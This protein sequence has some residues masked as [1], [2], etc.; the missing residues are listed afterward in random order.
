VHRWLTFLRYELL[1]HIK[2][3]RL[4]L[5]LG[6][7]LA[8][9]VPWKLLLL[10]E[11]ASETL[12]R[13]ADQAL[14][15]RPN[16]VL[17]FAG[18]LILITVD[19]VARVRIVGVHPLLFTKPFSPLSFLLAC[20]AALVTLASLLAGI[21]LTVRYLID[22][23]FFGLSLPMAPFGWIL[24]LGAIPL[25]IGVVAVAIWL[26]TVV[27]HNIS[28]CLITAILA[29]AIFAEVN[30]FDLPLLGCQVDLTV[31]LTGQ[32]VPSIGRDLDWARYVSALFNTTVVALLLVSLACYHTRRQEPQRKVL[33]K[34]GERWTD[35]P[36]FLGFLPNLKIDRHA[37]LAVHSAFLTT[38]IL[39]AVVGYRTVEQSMTTSSRVQRWAVELRRDLRTSDVAT[40]G[41][42][43]RNYSGEIQI[44]SRSRANCDLRMEVA[45]T[46]N[47]AVDRVAFSIPFG[48]EVRRF[49]EERSRPLRWRQWGNILVADLS[50]P[51]APG[52]TTT[53]RLAYEGS[54][55]VLRIGE[56]IPFSTN[57]SI[58][59]GHLEEVGLTLGSRY[60]YIN[61]WLLPKSLALRR[62]ANTLVSV[63]MPQLFTTDLRVALFN[64]L[65]MTSPNGL[66]EP[67]GQES[68]TSRVRLRIA[69][70][71][72]DFSLFA[73]PYQ[74][75]EQQFGSLVLHIHCFPAD[76]EIIE[77][78]LAELAE[79]V[80]RWGLL[81]GSAKGQ[82]C[83]LVE[84]PVAYWTDDRLPSGHLAATD[85]DRLRRYRPLLRTH[86]HEG[87]RA[88]DVYQ[89]RLSTVLAGKLLGESFHPD[90]Q[91]RPL[92]EALY[93][94]LIG[95]V[96]PSE[97]GP[98]AHKSVRLFQPRRVGTLT[99]F[100]DPVRAARFN[101]PLVQR[102]TSPTFEGFDA[103]HIW[104]ML[105]YLLEDDKFAAFLRALVNEYGDRIVTLADLRSLAERFYGGSLEWFFQQWFFGT[106]VP[107]LE[108][109]EARASMIENER[110]RDIEYDV[111]VVIA[112]KGQGRMPVPVVLQTERD[113]VTRLVWLDSDTTQTVMLHVPDRPETVFLDPE[114][115]ITQE[116]VADRET[117][118]RGPAWRKVRIIE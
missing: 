3:W 8:P 53:V 92:R 55:V 19:T 75:I 65:Q 118:T 106:G 111:R 33:G 84:A 105:H 20:W 80:E 7:L 11:I 104:R 30:A 66:I 42:M 9:T 31:P 93:W 36:T 59:V 29:G 52:C 6:V 86:Q 26:R 77:F 60:I 108:I 13:I 54:P 64:N 5:C 68:G 12:D 94:Y 103:T 73:G 62:E 100:L 39:V 14:A 41:L 49:E 22:R 112:N 79:T 91:I 87:I 102:L 101:T 24:F 44:P 38:V 2:S 46:T 81:L 32:Y 63:R 4:W 90:A 51:L 18:V 88:L 83:I 109:A 67:L 43:I 15:I 117:R 74:E 28:A 89:S 57:Y 17:L 76:R 47:S 78:A 21:P 48:M 56:Q 37:G 45:N 23:F 115:W 110:T 99:A 97:I 116:T 10:P 98:Y 107:K 71:R 34:Y 40:A 1:M 69:W 70:P 58:K 114:G 82:R 72:S 95:A 25:A 113:R 61:G 96:R 16:E 27:K 85:L 50:S 35:M